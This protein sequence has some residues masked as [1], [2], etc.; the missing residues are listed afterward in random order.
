LE[1]EWD[2]RVEGA[3][4][5]RHLLH[6]FQGIKGLNSAKTPAVGG[7]NKGKRRTTVILSTHFA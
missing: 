5:E 3:K 1:S 2:E 7:G 6:F 4:R